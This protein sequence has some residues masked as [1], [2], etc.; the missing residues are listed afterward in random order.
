MNITEILSSTIRG[1]RRLIPEDMGKAIL[2]QYGVCTPAGERVATVDEAVRAG[3]RLGYP[4]VV[5][6]LVPDLLHKSDQGAVKVGVA[7]EKELRETAAE[8]IDRFPGSSLLV[9]K[10]VPAGV[11]LI[12]GLTCDPLFGPCLMIGTGGIFTE[13]FQDVSFLILP[14]KRDDVHRALMG[15]K[16]YRLLR[17]FRGA[18]VYPLDP[19]VDAIMG[20]AQFAK[21]ADGYYESVDVNPLVVNAQG[22][23]ALDVKIVLRPDFVAPPAEWRPAGNIN[24]FFTPRSVA[25]I[26]ASFTPG[27]PGN[28]VIRNIL[29]NEYQGKIYLVNP[30]GGQLLGMPVC[31]SISDLPEGIDLAVIIVP[32]KDTPQAMRD[33]ARHGIKQM[34]LAAGGFAEVDEAGAQI[35][36]DMEG[37]IKENGLRVL[38]P[39][40]SGHISTPHK[41]TSSFFPIG[42]IRR[43]KISYIAQ[44]GNFATHTMKYILTGE[45]FGVARVIGLGNKIDIEESEALQFLGDDPETSAIFIYLESI[46]NPR[47]FLSAAREVTRRKPVLLL[48]GGATAAGKSAAVAHT[49]AMA[50]EDRLIDGMLSQAG[51]VRIY[52]YTQLVLAAKALSMMPLPRSN[53]ISFL[54]PSGALLVALSDLCTRL[55]LEIADVEQKTLQR[56]QEISSPFIRM[57]NPVDI[58]AAVM[59]SNVA[60]GYQEGMEAVFNDPQVD[61]VIAILMLTRETLASSYDFIVE[62]ARRFPKKPLLVSFSGDKQCIEECR[63]ILEP[64]GIPTFYEMEQPFEILSIMS[65]CRRML[66]WQAKT[67]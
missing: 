29:A 63:E 30:K 12:A 52:E 36:K 45:H 13:V 17:G 22:V 43:G 65:R 23:T 6:A 32:A 7:G 54:A 28:D 16:G 5:K 24:G 50:A 4:L 40:T 49:A 1:K 34:V 14:V 39:N 37:I 44:T 35:Q 8:F 61:A 20:V 26:G 42:K 58:W 33:C 18:P 31:A 48:K 19:L 64:Q 10:M 53:R 67:G 55:D 62:T 11:E 2:A 46:K 60:Q 9:E 59:A 51:I 3:A 38:G 41:F 15:L 56:L 21:E 25:I 57:R 47:R 66:D 27:K